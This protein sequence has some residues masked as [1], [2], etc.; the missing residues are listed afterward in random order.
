MERTAMNYFQAERI[1]FQTDEVQ[2]MRVHTQEPWKI[3]LRPFCC[4]LQLIIIHT[5]PYL[6]QLARLAELAWAT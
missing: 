5:L 6:L 3:W 4:C 2:T 1:S